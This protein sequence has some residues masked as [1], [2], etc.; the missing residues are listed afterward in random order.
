MIDS[1]LL[2]ILSVVLATDLELIPMPAATIER[3]L[4]AIEEQEDGSIE[5]YDR[6]NGTQIAGFD[7]ATEMIDK[8]PKMIQQMEEYYADKNL[9][10]IIVMK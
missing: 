4:F 10:D 3:Q 2:I 7:N 1:L 9:T 8:M 6:S 5:V